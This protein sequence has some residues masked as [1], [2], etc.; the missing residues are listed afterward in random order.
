MKR[1]SSP[2]HPH[3]TVWVAP[4]AAA[5]AHGHP[6]P[7]QA[8]AAADA[9]GSSFDMLTRLRTERAGDAIRPRTEHGLPAHPV[10]RAAAPARPHLHVSGF[11]PR[12]AGGRHAIRLE[13]RGMPADAP[14]TVTLLLQSD[15]LPLE[16]GPRRLARGLDGSWR[17][18]FLEFSS[19]GREHGQY[20]I[21]VEVHARDPDGAGTARTWVATLVLLVPR[22]DASLGEI[23][24]TFLSTHKNVRI[25][26]D[27]GSIARLSGLAGGGPMDI[28]IS[29]R[30]AGIAR[31]ALDAAQ[32]DGGKIAVGLPTIAWDEDLIEIDLP[33]ARAHPAPASAGCIVH[34]EPEA[35]FQRHLRLFALD[36]CVL[37]RHEPVRAEADLLLQHYDERGARADGLTRRLSGRHAIVRAGR[38][39]F[40][41]EDVSRYGLLLDGVWPGKHVPVLLR[42]GMRIELT[43]SIRGV[44]TLVVSAV[45]GHA[46]VLHRVDAGGAA[47]AFMLMAPG[48]EPDAAPAAGASLPRAAQL[49]LL[50]HRDGGF[51]HRDRASGQDTPLSAAAA[52]ERLSGFHGRV[53]FA[54]QPRPED[55]SRRSGTGERRR[56]PPSVLFG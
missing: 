12:A 55:G 24:Q 42:T 18:L 6:Q 13:L 49:P 21:D 47:E 31:L 16:S 2:A 40:E 20:R 56:A 37:G 32:A 43:A 3:C 54:A 38:N 29:A 50:F 27:D 23:H 14:G 44:V 45:L 5:C 41:I 52:L 46:V 51:W 33:A 53:R 30:N 26:A 28:D 34:A 4:G 35:G 1:C 9:L 7:A 19:R 11:D 15:L 22:A 39:G 25:S 8:S 10:R 17:P 36:E 48:V